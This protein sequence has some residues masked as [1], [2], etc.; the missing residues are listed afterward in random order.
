MLTGLGLLSF[1]GS[2]VLALAQ[3]NDRRLLGYSSVGQIGLVLAIVGQ[4]DILG[5][6]YFFVAGG[7]LIT[8]AVAKAG[9]FWLSGLV[10]G[11]V[12]HR[13]GDPAGQPAPDL[14]LRQSFVAMLVGLPPFP[15]FYAKWDLVHALVAADR[16]WIIGFVLLGALI[17]AGYMF[18]FFGFA[19]KRAAAE[20]LPRFAVDKV[21]VVVAALAAGWALG[22]AWGAAS[23]NTN[24]LTLVPFLF[25][26]AFTGAR[27]A[28]RP[29][30]RT[31]SPSPG[32][33]PG[34][35]S[36]RTITTRCR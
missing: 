30:S 14:R 29:G 26:L 10:P 18:R 2:N 8:H 33:W 6:S 21:G 24:L 7:V 11:R 36:A 22:F 16:Y 13:L 32:S 9:L 31:S 35:G 4:R 1:I 23:G 25:A 15:S 17:E 27:T 5:D 28:A 3:D 19:I 20:T 34:S 12:A